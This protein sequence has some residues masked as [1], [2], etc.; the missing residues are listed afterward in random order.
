M[1]FT[2]R[3]WFARI[4]IGLNKFLIGG[5]DAQGKQTLTNSPDSVTQEGD[6]ISADNLNDLEDRIENEFNAQVKFVK[7][8]EN[9]LNSWTSVEDI[10][11]GKIGRDIVIAFMPTPSSNITTAGC[12]YRFLRIAET[13]SAR[14]SATLGF[15]TFSNTGGTNGNSVNGRRVVTSHTDE[16]GNRI[17][18]I[19][20]Y[21]GLFIDSS[22]SASWYENDGYCIPFRIYEV[23]NAFEA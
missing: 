12:E 3:T 13:T 7:V 19:G 8:W 5:K 11:L 23:Q 10:N 22:P 4:G 17:V 2:K 21:E 1:A 16:S 18:N 9:P 6:V 15:T 20:H 14:T